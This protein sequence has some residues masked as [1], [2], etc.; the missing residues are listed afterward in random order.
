[1]NF[2][3]GNK[4]KCYLFRSLVA[5]SIVKKIGTGT[6]NFGKK[7]IYIHL[8]SHP[9]ISVVLLMRRPHTPLTSFFLSLLFYELAACVANDNQ[10]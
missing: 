5:V 4:S 1:M 10:P 7:N 3:R 6:L 8:N 9:Q 2:G